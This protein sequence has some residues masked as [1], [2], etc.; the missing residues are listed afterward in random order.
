MKLTKT[1]WIILIVGLLVIAAGTLGW[2]YSQRLDQQRQVEEQL[3][4]AQK[5]LA[6]IKL[7]D[8]NDQKDQFT[9]QIKE[10]NALLAEK[11]NRLKAPVDGIKT[12]DEILAK[13]KSYRIDILEMS[14]PGLSGEQLAGTELETLAI[15]IRFIGNINDIVNFAINLNELY[16]TSIENLVQLDRIAPSPT[17]TPSGTPTPNPTPT[18]LVTPVPPGFTP[19]T[20]PEKNFTGN[21]QLVIYNYEG[22]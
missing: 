2:M 7:D 18:T 6:L 13:A 4:A 21:I 14:S 16:P 10:L 5:K 8:L 22:N 11:K 17:P 12:T 19:I 9:K 1:S 3:S 15:S 20:A